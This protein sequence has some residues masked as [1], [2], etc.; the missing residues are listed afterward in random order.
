[1]PG[2]SMVG[3]ESLE[4]AMS[5]R[6]APR[7][8]EFVA[9]SANGRPTGSDPVD[10]GSTP[11]PAAMALSD[12][13]SL[14]ACQVRNRS[15]IL[16][17]AANAGVMTRW[18]GRSSPKRVP[19]GSN[20]VTPARILSGVRTGAVLRIASPGTWVQFPYSAPQR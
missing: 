8:P 1:M 15:S 14:R 4:L 16:R 11:A 17:G 18:E 5:V 7:Q 10:V 6:F 20:P 3:R 9:G 19:A 2:R 13:G 12:K